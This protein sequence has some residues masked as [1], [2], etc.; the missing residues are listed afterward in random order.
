MPTWVTAGVSI[1]MERAPWMASVTKSAIVKNVENILNEGVDEEGGR[2]KA[3]G[4]K[5][6]ARGEGEEVM[7]VKTS[8]FC[9]QREINSRV[10][11][12]L[13]NLIFQLRLLRLALFPVL[14]GTSNTETTYS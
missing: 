7:L 8:L 13:N 1:V 6:R 14:Q 11:T 2:Y 4:E 9:D 10:K 5:N 3:E 12:H